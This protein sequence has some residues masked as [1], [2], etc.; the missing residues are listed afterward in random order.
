MPRISIQP[1]L[2]RVASA[3]PLPDTIGSTVVEEMIQFGELCYWI[4]QKNEQMWFYEQLLSHR[5]YT[6][7][8]RPRPK[9]D[10]EKLKCLF[11]DRS[12]SLGSGI[13]SRKLV[14]AVIEMVENASAPGGA[15]KEFLFDAKAILGERYQPKFCSS[16]KVVMV[17][18]RG[19]NVY[20]HQ[21]QHFREVAYFAKFLL[22]YIGC[23]SDVFPVATSD[24]S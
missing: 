19:L 15:G 17:P 16:V 20:G 1:D 23:V 3:L 14:D 24:C 7:L 12:R 8:L 18:H 13:C 9:F 22:N 2:G 5:F 21:A 10:L 11:R 4:T 6:A